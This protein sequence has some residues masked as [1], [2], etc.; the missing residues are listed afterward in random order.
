[1]NHIEEVYNGPWENW[2]SSPFPPDLPSTNNALES[3]NGRYKI[4]GALQK[5][6]LF[7]QFARE[8]SIW[9]HQMS[10]ND[11]G[12]PNSPTLTVST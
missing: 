9:I 11:N 3:I 4:K 6:S 5:R 8:T 12:F 2:T 1:M 10:I 7:D